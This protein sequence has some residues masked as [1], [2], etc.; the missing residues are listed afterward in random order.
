MRTPTL[1][2]VGLRSGLRSGVRSNT[3]V[4]GPGRRSSSSSVS[5]VTLQRIRMLSTVGTHR[6]RGFVSVR[7]SVHIIRGIINIWSLFVE[8]MKDL[9]IS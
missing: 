1:L 4:T 2:C 3:R 8:I 6:A 7:P 9:K 5:T